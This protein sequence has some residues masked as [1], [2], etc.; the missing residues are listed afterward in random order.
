ML[1]AT[2]E[3]VSIALLSMALQGSVAATSMTGP[4]WGSSPNRPMAMRSWKYAPNSPTPSA[5]RPC[6]GGGW[7]SGH[8]HRQRRNP[9]NHNPGRGG[10]DTSAVALA[11]TET[12]ACEISPTCL[13]LTA[14]RKVE[15]Q[16]MTQVSC[17]EM[18][19]LASLG[20]AVCARAVEIARSGVPLIVRSSWSDEPGTRCSVSPAGGLAADLSWAS[21]WTER[22]CWKA[23]PWWPWPMCPMNLG[24]RS[25]VEELG[26]AG[27]NVDLIVQATHDGGNNDIAF[28]RKLSCRQPRPSAATTSAKAVSWRCKAGSPNSASAEPDHRATWSCRPAV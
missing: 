11:A 13:V 9:R 6:G 25:L 15:A 10:S 14:I 2:G 22:N 18:L 1:L 8:Q 12:D 17:D 5:R 28:T 19:E 26:A 3:Q 4:Q 16:L 24:W 21:P 20:A 23:K 27:L 7:L